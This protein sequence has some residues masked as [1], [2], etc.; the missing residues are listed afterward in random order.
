MFQEPK[1]GGF[2]SPRLQTSHAKTVEA[3]SAAAGGRER[4][5]RPLVEIQPMTGL[6]EVSK[7]FRRDFEL[8]RPQEPRVTRSDFGHEDL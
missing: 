2:I 8:R 6:F 5:I 1:S 7:N 4:R 3:L